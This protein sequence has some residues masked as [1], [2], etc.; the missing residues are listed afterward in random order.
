MSYDKILAK[1]AAELKEKYGS[2]IEKVILYGSAARGELGEES[3]IDVLVVV[4][5]KDRRI[6]REIEA[7]AVKTM[8]RINRLVSPLI[9]DKEAYAEMVRERY[10]FILRVRRE[11]VVYA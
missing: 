2:R 10:P 8:K 7:L 1:F 11:G 3:D 5:K 4:D 9:L 6:V